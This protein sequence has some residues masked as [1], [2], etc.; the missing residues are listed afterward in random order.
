MQPQISKKR[1]R[2]TKKTYK[3]KV[4]RLKITMLV[5]NGK[6]EEK[7]TTKI[8]IGCG[9]IYSPI[10]FILKRCKTIIVG[11]GLSLNTL[12]YLASIHMGTVENEALGGK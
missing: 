10:T 12:Y 9:R 5:Q 6:G 8:V 11:Q 2:K 7:K 3:V 1:K 4:Q